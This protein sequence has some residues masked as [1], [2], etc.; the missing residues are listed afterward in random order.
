MVDDFW[1]DDEWF[2]FYQQIK[3]VFPEREP[4]EVPLEHEIFQCVYPLQEK[5]QVPSILIVHLLPVLATSKIDDERDY[6]RGP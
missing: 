2:N 1:G 5:P 6:H 3:R 4:K